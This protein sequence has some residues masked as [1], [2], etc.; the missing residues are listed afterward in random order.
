MLH[1][2][3]QVK[4]ATFLSGKAAWC[5]NEAPALAVFTGNRSYSAWFY[6]ESVA[7]YPREAEYRSGRNNDFYAGAIADP[8]KFLHDN[9]ITGV[10]I[11]PDDAIPDDYLATLQ[12]KLASDYE[13]IDCKGEGAQNA[14]IFLRRPL[15]PEVT[16]P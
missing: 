6:F 5:Y 14:G 4:K 13:Y 2:M 12:T 15:P 9:N 3:E 8:L 10:V 1:I 16:Q 7:N 11:W